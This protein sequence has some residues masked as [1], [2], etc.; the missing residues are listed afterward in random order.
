MG[1]SL[2][3]FVA[4][5][6]TGKDIGEAAGVEVRIMTGPRGGLWQPLG[7]AIAE[8]LEREIPG[9]KASVVPGAGIVNIQEL[10][11]GGAEI[12]FG[13]LASTVDALAGRDP[14]EAPAKKIRQLSLLSFQYFQAVALEDSR[15]KSLG[16][17]RG[18]SL[19]VEP[20]GS[21]V[22]RVTRELLQI[23]GRSYRDLAK[24]SHGSFSDAV[25][26]MKENQVQAFTLINPAPSPVILDL[27]SA[28]MIR[29][30]S[31]PDD[32]FR[33]LQ[34]ISGGYSR[35]E[36]PKG[37]Y[38]GVDYD[39]QV[40]G[41]YTH[42]MVRADL[43]DDLVY[44]ITRALAGNVATLRAIAKDVEGLTVREMAMDVGVPYHPGALKF[45]K[46]ALVPDGPPAE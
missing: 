4:C 23:Y 12:G 17:L 3:W 25:A 8:I 7:A 26:L 31:V 14:F 28:R 22:E 40:F 10:E 9:T 20:P 38:P 34:K 15:I 24:V 35:R 21:T 6:A 2:G 30:L 45:Y 27:A 41:N 44:G 19:A 37:T 5:K 18:K 32:K 1:F 29:M 13:N 46:E 16:D 33:E 42:L 43:P 39:V 36:I 11:A